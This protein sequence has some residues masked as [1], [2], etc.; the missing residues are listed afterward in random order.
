MPSSKGSSR[1]RDETH[2]SLVSAL[3]GGSLPLAPPGKLPGIVKQTVWI[4]FFFPTT[5]RIPHLAGRDPCCLDAMCKWSLTD[6]T[7]CLSPRSLPTLKPGF[8][9]FSPTSPSSVLDHLY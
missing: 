2:I 6:S 5:H 7:S 9:P 1:P 8:G 3:A 4:P